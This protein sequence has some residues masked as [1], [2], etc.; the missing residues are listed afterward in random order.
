L[1]I[2]TIPNPLISSFCLLHLP[3]NRMWKTM[4][5]PFY[6]NFPISER[7][8]I[9]PISTAPTTIGLCPANW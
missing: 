2:A 5:K 4:T 1:T 6:S 9:Q 7:R 3:N 8:A